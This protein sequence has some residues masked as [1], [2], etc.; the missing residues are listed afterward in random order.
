MNSFELSRESLPQKNMALGERDDLVRNFRGNLIWSAV[1]EIIDL[2]PGLFSPEEIQQRL[3]PRLEADLGAVVEA[4]TGLTK[5]EIIKLGHG[6]YEK[7][8][9]TV[10]LDKDFNGRDA[11][12]AVAR[13]QQ[14]LNLVAPDHAHWAA[15]YGLRLS[16]H[17]LYELAMEIEKTVQRYM[18]KV[19]SPQD[20]FDGAYELFFGGVMVAEKDMKG[21]RA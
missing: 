6:G 20:P 11:D 3:T 21:G 2:T 18:A 1:F 9:S 10:F 7:I 5:L 4:V 14:A 16:R 17:Q 13:T 8:E 19:D 12:S 15:N